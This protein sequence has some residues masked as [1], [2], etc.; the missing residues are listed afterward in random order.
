MRL[1]IRANQRCI[2]RLDVSMEPQDV[3]LLG[4]NPRVGQ[5]SANVRQGKGGRKRAVPVL[6]GKRLLDRGEESLHCKG[7][8]GRLLPNDLGFV[9]R[10]AAA[11]T[12]LN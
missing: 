1:T 7:V 3:T 9:Q 8:V 10:A 5:P 6:R 12:A 4:G 2:A 11:L